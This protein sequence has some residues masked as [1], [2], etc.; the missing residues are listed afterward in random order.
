MRGKAREAGRELWR[1]R[2]AEM[3]GEI[4]PGKEFEPSSSLL[5]NLGLTSLE[6]N[7]SRQATVS[8]FHPS[9]PPLG[10]STLS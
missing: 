10:Q 2:Q 5:V 1:G 8:S 7:R 4:G 6:N 3:N 9:F